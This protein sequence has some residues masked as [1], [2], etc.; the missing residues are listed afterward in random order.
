MIQIKNLNFSYKKNNV[1]NSIS[2]ELKNSV[3]YGLQGKN[4]SGKT[5]L[6]K[7]ISGIL[8]E[9]INSQIFIDNTPLNK[10][11]INQRPAF[12]TYIPSYIEASFPL[13]VREFLN[14]GFYYQSNQETH[15]NIKFV[16]KEIYKNLNF[17]NSVDECA[18][19]FNFKDFLNKKFFSCSLG[20]KQFFLILKSFFHH[21]Q[22]Y[23]MDECF[24]HLDTEHKDVILNI[25]SDLKSKG[26]GFLI[27]SHQHD[28]LKLISNEI[29]LLSDGNIKILHK[30]I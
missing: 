16:H 23:L 10:I 11:S 27:S 14:L 3:I 1:L 9:K 22:F 5:T 12:I 7:A 25:V 18:E 24:S 19:Q 2:L 15:D 20:E 29:F 13:T 26:C 28:F 21:A 17:L 4:G 6:M 8:S 30:N